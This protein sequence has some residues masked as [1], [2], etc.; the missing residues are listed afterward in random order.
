MMKSE[1]LRF[2]IM[3]IVA[4]TAIFA[5]QHYLEKEANLQTY[6]ENTHESQ[7]LDR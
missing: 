2:I 7:D 3:V 6:K 5:L 4:I 1:P